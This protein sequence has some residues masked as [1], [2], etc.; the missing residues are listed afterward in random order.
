MT[1]VPTDELR[2]LADSLLSDAASYWASADSADG[3][4]PLAFNALHDEAEDCE[5]DARNLQAVAD[6]LDQRRASPW[7]DME[8]APRDGTPIL[9][10]FDQSYGREW[11]H[12][13]FRSRPY[14]PWVSAG[15]GGKKSFHASLAVR[16][17]HLPPEGEQS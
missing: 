1:P 17:M 11:H 13:V 16:W 2:K 9:V 15:S 4:D 14:N 7:R 12:V 3:R 6:E 5:Q 8:T 10:E